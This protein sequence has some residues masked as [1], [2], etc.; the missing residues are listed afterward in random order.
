M[1]GIGTLAMAT[2]ALE[3]LQ[4]L[5]GGSKYQSTI[6][7]YRKAVKGYMD[8]FKDIG[9]LCDKVPGKPLFIYPYNGTPKKIVDGCKLY[10]R[11]EDSGHYS[12][13]LQGL[14]LVHDATPELGADDELMT[15]VGNSIAFANTTK[16]TK[17]GRN[18]YSGHI[19]CPTALRVK[20]QGGE[21][22]KRHA[23]SKGPGSKRFYLLE[24]FRNGLIDALNT[25][26]NEG[27]KVEA[28]KS[29]RVEILHVHY[30]KAKQ[31]NP[32]LIHLGEGM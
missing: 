3:D 7:R 30:L 15:A 8:N 16:I 24:G 29:N 1:N 2:A 17:G 26:A 20:P 10:G 25:T 27:Q 14:M 11:T 22:I 5:K 12:H 9:H 32:D 31:N 13:L 28:A 21:N 18:E 19:Q 6:T 23:F 4:A